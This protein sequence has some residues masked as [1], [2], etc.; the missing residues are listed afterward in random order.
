MIIFNYTK[1]IFK[2][3]GLKKARIFFLRSLLSYSEVVAWLKYIDSFYKKYDLT[4]APSE[5]AGL[6]IRSYASNIFKIKQRNIILQDHYRIMEYIFSPLAIKKFLSDEEISISSL[7]KKNGNQCYLK[8]LMHGKFWREGAMTLY[9]EDESRKLISTLTFTI[10]H[11]LNGKK[12]IFI[13][14]LQG[15]SDIEKSDIVSF[16]RSL[17]GLRPK[18]T[19]I[20]CCYAVANAIGA[21][22]IT[23]VSN[24]NHVFSYQ[25]TF[26]KS[27]NSI[28][29]EIGSNLDNNGNYLLPKHL[30]KRDFESVPQKKRKDWLIRHAHIDKLTVDITHFLKE[31]SNNT[32]K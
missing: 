9:L 18:H 17:G 19:L 4:S 12:S 30:E 7:L 11:D 26:Q 10:Y 3:R 22:K 28:W 1:N 32:L 27:Y 15:G 31:N 5:M 2:D 24:E 16:T 6:P 8:I 20:E 29:E 13:G 14:G 25:K 23:G 21:E